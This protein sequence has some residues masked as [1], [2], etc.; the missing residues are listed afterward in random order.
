[1]TSTPIAF[2]PAGRVVAQTWS[3]VYLAASSKP[4]WGQHSLGKGGG[5]NAQAFLEGPAIK[6]EQDEWFEH[7]GYPEAP[8]SIKDYSK[9]GRQRLQLLDNRTGS[10]ITA[11]QAVV[12]SGRQFMTTTTGELTLIDDGVVKLVHQQAVEKRKY[13]MKVVKYILS[14]PS[15]AIAYMLLPGETIDNLVGLSAMPSQ[16]HIM[17]KADTLTGAKI[18]QLEFQ[19][20]NVISSIVVPDSL[21]DDDVP[22]PELPKAV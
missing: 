1:M 21:F 6:R 9:G 16:I 12:I 5:L 15:D 14:D 4:H 13:I 10:P 8:N 3:D 18:Q 2:G 17:N 20:E 22:A 11:P 7:H 19:V